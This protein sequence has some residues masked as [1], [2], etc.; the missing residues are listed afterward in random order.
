MH[1]RVRQIRDATI[2]GNDSITFIVDPLETFGFVWEPQRRYT[3]NIDATAKSPNK[4]TDAETGIDTVGGLD[5]YPDNTHLQRIFES[6]QTETHFGSG[7]FHY[8]RAGSVEAFIFAK[9]QDTEF[10]EGVPVLSFISIDVN[11]VDFHFQIIS[12]TPGNYNDV[13]VQTFLCAAVQ[14]ASPSFADGTG[15]TFRFNHQ[16]GLPTLY[17]DLAFVRRRPQTNPSLFTDWSFYINDLSNPTEVVVAK[18]NDSDYFDS[19]V[20]GSFIYSNVNS[21]F[22]AGEKDTLRIIGISDI[23]RNGIASKKFTVEKVDSDSFTYRYEGRLRSQLRPRNEDNPVRLFFT[24][25][26]FPT[27]QVFNLKWAGSNARVDSR[28]DGIFIEVTGTSNPILCIRISP[29]ANKPYLTRLIESLDSVLSAVQ[30]R[31]RNL[32]NQADSIYSDVTQNPLYGMIRIDIGD[33]SWSS[34]VH[35]MYQRTIGEQRSYNFLTNYNQ[36]GNVY[37]CFLSSLLTDGLT[38]LSQMLPTVAETNVKLTIRNRI[39]PI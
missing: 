22:N 14:Q 10:V 11:G 37:L 8:L 32:V 34:G 27:E 4:G 25:T 30:S 18:E 36:S 21:S 16:I 39:F 12:S 7:E 28:N 5:D 17:L 13:A 15:Y 29:N 23:T 3:I 35:Y 9:G 24:Y 33:N 31:I 6:S 19:I 2:N 20:N 38:P 26:P 1:W